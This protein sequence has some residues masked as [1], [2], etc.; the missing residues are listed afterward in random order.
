[1]FSPREWGRLK[2]DFVEQTFEQW[3]NL[4]PN[5]TRD[6]LIASRIYTP[7]DVEASHPDMI[8][9]GWSEGAMIASQLGRF[10]PFPE[11]SNYRTPVE[12]L[13][14]C[15]SNLHS[16]GGIG[17]GSSLNCYQVM[18]EDLGLNQ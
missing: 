18:A 5:M 11:L 1:M 14:I 8:Q 10:R 4:A 2:D 3:Q 7:Y 16:A 6:N 12:N 17:R 13:Y 15:S 9:G